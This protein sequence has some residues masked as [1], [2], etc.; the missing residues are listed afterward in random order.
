VRFLLSP[1]HRSTVNE[2][3]EMA[4]S[5]HPRRGHKILVASVGIA[6]MSFVGIGC[7]STSVANLMAPPSCD[8]APTN[9]YCLP[10]PDSGMDSATD[11]GLDGAT[12][13]AAD[14]G[15]TDVSTG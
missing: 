3:S 5:P 13:S 4:S 7:G 1:S 12:D 6:T 10:S 14:G 15:A 8:V 9:P 2:V 11:S